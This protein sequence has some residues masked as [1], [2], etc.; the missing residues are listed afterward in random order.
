MDEVCDKVRDQWL[1]YQYEDV[2]DGWIKKSIDGKPTTS[3]SSLAFYWQEVLERC[4][5]LEVGEYVNSSSCYQRND[6]YW[7]KL[8]NWFTKMEAKSTHNLLIWLL[9]FV[10]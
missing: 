4:G 7:K 5:L 2:K 10:H 6:H 9:P 3:K 1:R 8:M